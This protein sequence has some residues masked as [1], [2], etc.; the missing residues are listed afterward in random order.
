MAS[1]SF[2]MPK[3][4]VD[5][6]KGFISLCKSRPEIIHNEELAFFR[7]YL[8]SM[9]A[10]LPPK[11]EGGAAPDAAK[12]PDSKPAPEPAKEEPAEMEVEESD[13]SDV[14]L[15][16]EGVIGKMSRHAMAWHGFMSRV[17][18]HTVIVTL[19]IYVLGDPNPDIN[20][21]MGDPN[22]KELT[23]QEM[24]SFDEKRSEAM[25]TF[26]EVIPSAYCIMIMY[27]FIYT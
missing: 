27:V 23:E 26:S 3:S 4:A 17:A 15:D 12:K 22:K 9:G 7:D 2:S 21:E 16:M 10:T 8:L 20:Q 14:E 11:P 6:L 13:E 1:M 25:Q 18:L 24:E 19:N 5:Q